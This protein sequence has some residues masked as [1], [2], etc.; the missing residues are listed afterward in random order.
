MFSM[1]RLTIVGQS[2]EGVPRFGC[3]GPSRRF[4]ALVGRGRLEE[5]LGKNQV[6][7]EIEFSI[8]G[9]KQPQRWRERDLHPSVPIY[10]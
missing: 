8:R 5:G 1:T 7:F 4:G 3:F 6:H 2:E 9:N 10:K